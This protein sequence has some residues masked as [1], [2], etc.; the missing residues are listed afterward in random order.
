M[1]DNIELLQE[2]VWLIGFGLNCL[3]DIVDKYQKNF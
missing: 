1:E 2:M 3:C